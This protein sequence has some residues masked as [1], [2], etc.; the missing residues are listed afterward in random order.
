MTKSE[1]LDALAVA[2]ALVSLPG[3]R[4]DESAI[5]ISRKFEFADFAAAFAFMTSVAHVAEEMNHHPDWRNVFNRVEV[6]L[7]THDAGGITRRD[8]ELARRMNDLAE[9]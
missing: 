1:R 5:A 3:W 6:T 2:A 4:A 9:L 7:T 8:L